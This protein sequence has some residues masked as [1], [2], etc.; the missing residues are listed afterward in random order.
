M[1]LVEGEKVPTYIY[2]A[3]DE[4]GKKVRGTMD[5][6]SKAELASKLRKMGYMVTRMSE[7]RPGINLEGLGN[8]FKRI[9]VEDKIMFNIQLANMINSGLGLLSCLGTLRNQIENKK[10]KEVVGDVY[11]N[12]EGGSSFSEA[13]ARHPRI[14]SKLFVSMVRAGEASG[15]LDTVLNR[16]AVFAERQADLRQKI[17]GALFY[18]IIL[19]VAA[20]AI[21]VFIITFVMPNFVSIFNEAGVALPAP[22]VMLYGLG[23]AVKRYW[24][25]II[26]GVILVIVGI[27]VYVRT[28]RGRL[29]FD[30]L[31]LKLPVIGPLTR[32]LAISRFART[33]ATM[34]ASGVPILQSLD[35]VREVIGNEVIARVVKTT[36]DGVAEG[37]RIAEPLKV[38]EEFPPD[39]VQMIAVGEESGNLDGMLNKISDF[40]DMAVGYSIRKLTALL[41]PAFL[42]VIGG[43]V[44]FIMASMLLPMFDMV[45]ALRR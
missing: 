15:N 43:V 27:R 19:V 37:E 33:L 2:K 39:T 4:T 41:E 11:R 23:L 18:P 20:T 6:V 17:R 8:R 32:K 13:L 21:V 12:V 9:R 35:I 22:T 42:V 14:F 45:K 3:R 24:W 25:L 28:D 29:G 1:S 38:S 44:A 40:Y 31:K 36:R 5:A 34:V 7:V 16:L 26:L 10:L 30:R